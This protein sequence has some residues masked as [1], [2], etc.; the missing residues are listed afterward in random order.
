M[1]TL[2]DLEFNELV[3]V[4]R[5]GGEI[6]VWGVWKRRLASFHDPAMW[7][8]VDAFPRCFEPLEGPWGIG[9]YGVVVIDFDNRRV[10][11]MC[12]WSTPSSLNA[13]ASTGARSSGQEDPD[14]APMRALGRRPDQWP[15]VRLTIGSA[16]AL[17]EQT[18][19]ALLGA[20]TY[21]R[22]L[23]SVDEAETIFLDTMTVK[24]GLS[25]LLANPVHL[26]SGTY[27]PAG[28]VQADDRDAEM[29]TWLLD[30]LQALQETG[31]PPPAWDGFDGMM[32]RADVPLSAELLDTEEDEELQQCGRRYQDLKRTWGAPAAARRPGP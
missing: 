9:P 12:D 32:E 25:S 23:A 31:F 24:H 27:L 29:P 6:S 20:E 16:A 11:S 15:C 22:A 1:R 8:S 17:K 13:L 2:D 28:W 18:L 30:Q 10:V 7:E 26:Q 19:P 3:V 4:A 5:Q 21:A 14:R